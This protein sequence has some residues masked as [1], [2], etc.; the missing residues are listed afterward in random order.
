ML[1]PWIKDTRTMLQGMGLSNITVGTSDAGSYFN[2]LVLENVDYGVRMTFNVL[3]RVLT[4]FTDGERASV[5]RQRVY[6]GCRRVDC[7]FLR[8]QRCCGCQCT[9]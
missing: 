2:N 5:V 6:Y 3:Y 4:C 9:L 1:I 7:R 8:N